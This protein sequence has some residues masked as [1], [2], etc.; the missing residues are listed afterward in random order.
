MRSFGLGPRTEEV[1]L[2]RQKREGREEFTSFDAGA[3]SIADEIVRVCA[4]E[5]RSAMRQ[6]ATF[7][8]WDMSFT[9]P[10]TFTDVLGFLAIY[11][12]WLMMMYIVI[13]AGWL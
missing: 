2:S 8:A 5:H 6:D 11:A 13:H 4:I 12:A 3:V 1:M 10:E 7:A 9:S